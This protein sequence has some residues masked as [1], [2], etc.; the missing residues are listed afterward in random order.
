MGDE[1][2]RDSHYLCEAQGAIPVDQPF[3][4]G[5]RYPGDPDGDASEVVNCRCR[6]V[7]VTR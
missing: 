2:L 6:L 5:L 3:Q 1:R 7:G 4:N